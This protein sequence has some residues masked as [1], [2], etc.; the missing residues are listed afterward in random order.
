MKHLLLVFLLAAAVVSAQTST[1]EIT[2]TIRDSSGA[3]IPGATVTATNEATGI[4]YR[5][6]TT[7]SG[8]FAFPALPAGTYS[9]TAEMKGFRTSKRAGNLLVVGTPL[10]V[11]LTLE[12]GQAS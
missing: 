12:V 2:G 7:Q 3:V 11:D 9:V 8:L 5:Q 1:S 10:A 4:S 6:E